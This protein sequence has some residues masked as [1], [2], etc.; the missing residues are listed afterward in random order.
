MNGRDGLP[1]TPSKEKETRQNSSS[2]FGSRDRRGAAAAS[3]R[4]EILRVTFGSLLTA[5]AAGGGLR[6]R[7]RLL[8][9]L[10]RR[11]GVS[12]GHRE[13]RFPRHLKPF[14]S[15]AS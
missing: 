1:W 11:A 15:A 12:A 13:G 2:A 9:P 7:N 6:F 10:S 4:R 3:I 14:L 8:G 5:R